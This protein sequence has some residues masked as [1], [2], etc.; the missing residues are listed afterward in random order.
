MGLIEGSS[1]YT[2]TANVTVASLGSV[3]QP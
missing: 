3:K 2:E 1:I